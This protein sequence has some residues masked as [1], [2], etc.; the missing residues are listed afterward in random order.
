[1]AEQGG[2]GVVL[3]IMVSTTLTAVAHVLDV[4]FPRF[5]KYIAESTGH[6]A[7][8]GYYEAIATGK[9]RI[10]PFTV[11]LAWDSDNST[12]AAM[13][14]AFGS[15]A[16]VSMSIEDPE[17]DEV[18]SFSAHIEAIGRIARQE[19]VVQ[20]EVLIHPTGKATIT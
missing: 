8:D 5:R 15:D 2:F 20:A 1:M 4:D 12:H 14:T 3:K 6:D 10:E 7:T 9:R 16:A 11:R 18:I 13:V 17:G 19:D